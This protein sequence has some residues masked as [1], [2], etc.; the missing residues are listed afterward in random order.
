[1]PHHKPQFIQGYLTGQFLLAMPNMHDPRFERAVVYIF[2]HDD[3]G[4]MGFVINHRAEDIDLSN[5]N[6]NL[7]EIV[8]NSGLAKLPVFIGGPV[9]TDHGFVLHTPDQAVASTLIDAVSKIAVTQTLDILTM[10]ANGEGPEHIKLLIGY[11]GWS[12]GQLDSELREN[13]WI[14]APAKNELT[15]AIEN[16]DIYQKVAEDLGINVATLAG[17]GGQA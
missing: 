15:F 16:K 9:Q 13:A 2:A 4:A 12:A 3:N 5:V 14:V 10:I 7:P 1:M 11:T 17:D 6:A 8:R